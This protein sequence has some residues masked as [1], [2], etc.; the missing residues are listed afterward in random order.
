[1][2]TK[3]SPLVGVLLRGLVLLLGLSLLPGCGGEDSEE[4]N[5]LESA[6]ERNKDLKKLIAERE[7]TIEELRARIKAVEAERAAGVNELSQR[8]QQEL[9]RLKAAYQDKLELAK[10]QFEQRIVDLETTISDL[11]IQLGLSEKQRLSL[12]GVVDQPERLAAI[13]RANFSMERTMWVCLTT[14][15][16]AVSGIFASQYFR[17]RAERRKDVVKLIAQHS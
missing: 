4:H 1:M 2:R 14:A 13:E 17:L 16:L 9:D 11:R 7:S 15:C 8:H 5:Q 12:K 3:P 10:G 6:N